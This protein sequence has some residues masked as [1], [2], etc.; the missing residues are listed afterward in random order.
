MNSHNFFSH[1]GS[2]GQRLP[3]GNT[4]I[5]SDT[6]GH[7]FE[8]TPDGKLAWEY[9]NPVTRDGAVKVLG[10]VLPMT[11]SLFRAYRY[12]S[13]HPAL[14]G[15]E[16]TPKGTIT[17]REPQGG[18]PRSSSRPFTAPIAAGSLLL[19]AMAVAWP[20]VRTARKG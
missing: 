17:G 12:G 6:E 15:R 1:I 9:I 20:A 19:I 13:D 3:N 18:E 5:C 14:K 4:F 7:L 16:L 2:S 8:V 10:D 11:N